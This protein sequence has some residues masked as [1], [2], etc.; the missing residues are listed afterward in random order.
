[1]KIFEEKANVAMYIIA[2]FLGLFGSRGL[3]LDGRPVLAIVEV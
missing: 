3:S 1:M 2:F